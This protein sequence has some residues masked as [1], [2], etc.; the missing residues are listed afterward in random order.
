MQGL[1]L[2]DIHT[3]HAD[4]PGATAIRS[5][6]QE[7][8]ESFAS[9][10]GECSAGLHPWFLSNTPITAQQ[11]WLEAALSDPRVVLLGE[12]GLDR[13]RGP[14]LRQQQHLFN[15]QLAL[16]A[17]HH[18]P[19][20]IHCVR[21]FSELLQAIRP[22]IGQ[23]PFILHGFNRSFRT[24]EPFLALGCQV[25]FGAAILTPNGAAAQ[26]LQ[27]TPAE[28]LFLETDNYPGDIQEIYQAAAALRNTTV[29]HLL[30]I[31]AH[32][33]DQLRKV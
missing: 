18:K 16:A 5:F 26:S 25:S 28:A 4:P 20:I 11:D 1:N 15:Y 24:L 29:D 33:F 21:A 32:N 7:E 22:W 10:T 23:I 14:D 31:I 6:S 30:Q 2:I 9:W 13:L 3:H 19:V 12:A 8:Q 17:R 27:Q